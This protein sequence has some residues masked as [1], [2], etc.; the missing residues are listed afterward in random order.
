[1][2]HLTPAQQLSIV[3]LCEKKH[4]LNLEMFLNELFKNSLNDLFKRNYESIVKRGLID[5]KPMKVKFSEKLAE[6]TAEFDYEFRVGYEKTFTDQAKEEL[7][8]VQAVTFNIQYH[9]G[10]DFLSNFLKVIEKNE[11]R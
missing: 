1:M 3:A 8:D 6:E 11:N 10:I 4:F 2:I 9:Y 5:N 7:A